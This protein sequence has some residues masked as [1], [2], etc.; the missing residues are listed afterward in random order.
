[1]SDTV[2]LRRK[3]RDNFTILPNDLIRDPRLSW[4]GLGLLAFLLSCSESYQ[5]SL[6]GLTTQKKCGREATRARIKELEAHGYLTITVVRDELGQFKET[7]WEVTDTPDGTP[8]KASGNSATGGPETRNPRSGNP[9]PDDP[10]VDSPVSVKPTLINTD[11][12]KLPIKSTTTYAVRRELVMPGQLADPDK[13]AILDLLRGVASADAQTLLDELA[14]VMAVPGAIKTT[15]GRWFYG[16]VQKYTQGQFNPVGAQRVAAR[17]TV[18]AQKASAK[19]E[20]VPADPEVARA[21]LAKI[22]A[23]LHVSTEVAK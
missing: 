17:R 8:C 7:L 15:P 23:A 16:L 20:R 9:K 4:G 13:A 6:A 2:I 12:R 5:F 10:T 1:M 14:S 21:H 22:A 11:T 19:V 3:V 18:Q